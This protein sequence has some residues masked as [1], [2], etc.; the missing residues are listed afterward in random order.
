[1]FR[2]WDIQNNSSTTTLN[3]NVVKGLRPTLFDVGVT[4]NPART[5]TSFIISHDRAESNVDVII[6]IF[7]TSGRQLW[8]HAE[9]GVSA[10]DSYM[11]DWDLTTDGGRPLNTGVYLYRIKVAADGSSYTSK[12][13]KLIIIR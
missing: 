12:T 6:E 9:S 10:S 2:A 3:F 11:V 7:D 1:M 4:E 8:R 5:S 13:R